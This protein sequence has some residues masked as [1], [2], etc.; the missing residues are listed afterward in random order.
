MTNLSD[1]IHAGIINEGDKFCFDEIEIIENSLLEGST[2]WFSGGFDIE[3][4]NDIL[5]LFF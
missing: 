4:F 2:L 5:N 3:F 1:D